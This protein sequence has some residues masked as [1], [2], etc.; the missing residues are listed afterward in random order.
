MQDTYNII[1]LRPIKR[2]NFNL[3]QIKEYFIVTEIL[4]VFSIPTA[5]S[6]LRL[7]VIRQFGLSPHG[8]AFFAF[9]SLLLPDSDRTKLIY[10]LHFEGFGSF[11]ISPDDG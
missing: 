10:L 2:T 3:D 8:L 11:A 7:L 6:I 9:L 4:Q 1:Q 5:S